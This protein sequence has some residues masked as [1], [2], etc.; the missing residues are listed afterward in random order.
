MKIT[1]LWAALL[2]AALPAWAVNKCTGADGRISF[3]DAPCP[4]G[5]IRSR[6]DLADAKREAATRV[7]GAVMSPK[8]AAAELQAQ[9][10]VEMKK[11]RTKPVRSFQPSDEPTASSS[12]VSMP[13]SQCLATVESTVRSLAVGWKDVRRIVNSPE[14]S[15]TKICTVDG[16]VIITCSAPDAKM[17]TTRGSK[18]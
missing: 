16:S 2:L 10:E 3:Q 9:L 12:A 13:M 11:E 1:L 14:T 15:M 17:V 6:D 7:G 8:Q 4:E 18:C 5:S